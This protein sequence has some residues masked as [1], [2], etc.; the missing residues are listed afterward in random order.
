MQTAAAFYR[1]TL[2]WEISRET[3]KWIEM[4]TGALLI[5]LCQDEIREATF[6]MITDDLERAE[7]Y[8]AEHG[9]EKV[10]LGTGELFVRDPF[11]YL[12]CVSKRE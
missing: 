10:D 5:Y 12:T 7:A 2:G 6:D 11:G 4:K 8:L 3:E 1:D 9:C